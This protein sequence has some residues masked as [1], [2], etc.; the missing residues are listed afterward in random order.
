LLICHK[1]ARDIFCCDSQ[2]QTSHTHPPKPRLPT[3]Q[4]P[5]NGVT[6]QSPQSSRVSARARCRIG[7]SAPGGESRAP[8][9]GWSGGRTGGKLL[10]ARETSRP[11]SQPACP[12][13]WARGPAGRRAAFVSAQEDYAQAEGKPQSPR[14][15][16]SNL[17]PSLPVC[18][19][20]AFSK[21]SSHTHANRSFP[22]SLPVY[23]PI[24][25]SV[26]IQ[27]PTHPHR[28]KSPHT[29]RTAKY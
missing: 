29:A 5:G 10:L 26:S 3:L 9:E 16:N 21:T 18:S 7:R 17:Q 22:L 8:S 27:Q 4:I 25:Y 11:G 2:C 19:S 20:N 1:V 14:R 6:E 28:H 12:A 24:I 13:A 23:T 15:A